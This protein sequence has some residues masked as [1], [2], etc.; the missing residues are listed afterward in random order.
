[1]IAKVDKTCPKIIS[2]V[3]D[4]PIGTGQAKTA[5]N[6]YI[7]HGILLLLHNCDEN[8]SRALLQNRVIP[9][10]DQILNGVGLKC[11]V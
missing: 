11:S 10:L 9:I 2:S 5:S 1:M 8:A 4:S 3:E 6:A 7:L